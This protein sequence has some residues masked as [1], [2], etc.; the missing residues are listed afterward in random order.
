MKYRDRKFEKSSQRL[1]LPLHPSSPSTNPSFTNT[2]C[3]S[4]ILFNHLQ[5]SGVY[6]LL[7]T[8]RNSSPTQSGKAKRSGVNKIAAFQYDVVDFL[9]P[10][11]FILLLKS[12]W[13]SFSIVAEQL[14]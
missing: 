8:E 1:K 6:Q 9:N 10:L 7:E 2:S 4:K 5:L 3:K 13:Q 14:S 11:T 12:C